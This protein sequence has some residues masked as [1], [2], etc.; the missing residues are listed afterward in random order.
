MAQQANNQ[1]E[2]K[3]GP[4]RPPG[5]KNK[6]KDNQT[7]SPKPTKKEVIE[8]MQR[9]NDRDR[10]NLD[11][12]WSI[13]LF[14]V[15]LFLFFTVVMDSTGSFGMKVHDLCLGL[16]GIMAYALPFLVFIF[17]GLL[18]AGKLQHIGARTAVFSI[19]I[20]INMCILNSYRFIDASAL[21]FGFGDIVDYYIA[22]IDKRTGGVFGM[23]IG[24][25]L[26][27]FFGMP[28][29]LIISIA[30][31]II[32]IFLV[33]NTPISRFFEELGKKRRNRLY[34]KE[35]DKEEAAIKREAAASTAVRDVSISDEVV[36]AQNK[37]D[38]IW[39]SILNGIVREEPETV[40][41]EKIPA[42]HASAAD[43]PKPIGVL[44][45]K[46][47]DYTKVV[48]SPID[49]KKDAGAKGTLFGRIK[50]YFQGID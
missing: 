5:S 29:L 19:L 27:K 12:I 33:A 24:S 22:G 42:P 46:D 45:D 13:T 43:I 31:L 26:V 14:A 2:K 37:K 32:S 18:M 17:A 50:G 8:E 4:G 48:D 11:V 16:F 39:R 36:P 25:I 23:E 30:V 40:V 20:F 47:I 38:S 9:R 3:R 44:D 10:R 1:T 35:L 21:R 49:I 34:S 6:P 7:S 41:P 15:G 28:G